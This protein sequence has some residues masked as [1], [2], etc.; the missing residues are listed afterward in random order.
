MK[1]N[2]TGGNGYFCGSPVID[3]VAADSKNIYDLNG[4]VILENIANV[5]DGA[6]SYYDKEGNVIE[7]ETIYVDMKDG[8]R[9]IKI[10]GITEFK[11]ITDNWNGY[12]MG[13]P[14]FQTDEEIIICDKKLEE[15]GRISNEA[16]EQYTFG[17][18]VERADGMRRYYSCK[19]E[20]LY[21]K[22]DK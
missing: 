17:I 3:G 5:W 9:Y 7:D 21:E 10:S 15:I 8:T 2:Y 14:T 1:Y 16:L 12:F 6:G 19:G 11:Q 4:K 13:Y 20:L 18:Y 22:E